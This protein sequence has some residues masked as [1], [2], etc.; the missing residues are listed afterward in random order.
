MQNLK[1]NILHFLQE[2]KGS[3]KFA[4]IQTADFLFPGLEID[5]VGEVAFP[6]NRLQAEALIEVAHKAPF[7]K[8]RETILDATV[9]SAWEIDADRLHFN[10][11]AWQKFLHKLIRN[12]KSDLGLEDY[13]VAAHLYKL[14]IYE[15]GDFFLPHKD[16]E[17]EKGM[18]G[19]LII[20]LPSKHSGG[21]L[22]ISFD[23]VTETAHFAE[24]TSNHAIG[25][26]AFYVD[27]DH[28]VKPVTSGHRVCLVYNLIQKKADE[29]IALQ[30]LQNHAQKLAREFAEAE[31]HHRSPFVTLLG[32]QYTPENFSQDMLKLNDRGKAEVLLQ[33]VR[34]NGYYAKL[35][36]VTS[37]QN[38]LPKSGSYDYYNTPE[39]DD[40]EME[41]V[42]DENLSIAHWANDG[43]P[44]FDEI[45]LE[46]D[47]IITS[48]ALGEGEP[49]MKENSG[50]MGNY[51][52]ELMYWYHYGAVMI[53]SPEQ[54]AEMLL[55]QNTETQ[56]QWIAHF[57]QA[58]QVSDEEIAAVEQILSAGLTQR[59]KPSG[60]ANFNVVANWLIQQKTMPF[61][62][63]LNAERLQYFFTLI[64]ADHWTKLLSN[65]Q[66]R[67]SKKILKSATENMTKPV[68][69]KIIDIIK[70]AVDSAHLK[71]TALEQMH[72]LPGYLQAITAEGKH[73]IAVPALKELFWIAHHFP[74]EFP[75]KA[76]A[77]SLTTGMRKTYA[78][79]VLVPQVLATK[80]RSGFVELLIATC[81]AFMKELVHNKPEPPTDWR[82]PLPETKSYG[83]QWEILKP[84]M[85]S[86]DDMRF[87]FCRK[88][89][90]RT[91]MSEAIRK[92]TVDL[93]TETIRKGSP[94]TL[95][96]TKTQ[97]S[98][99]VAR[100]EWEGD[101]V[102]LGRLGEVN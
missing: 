61:L 92:V 23:G 40:M 41:E 52:P 60:T 7:G 29:P 12:V 63:K 58:E 19:T 50:Y 102:L 5:G 33:V 74:D 93:K 15:N 36:L 69:E 10:N 98:Y 47:D 35:C 28:E 83:E 88:L 51:G 101:V 70:V 20:G 90:E 64:D 39:A 14:L 2:L 30:S 76:A 21:E 25:C 13:T 22:V 49:V 82:R 89:N 32:H 55:S 31:E 84:F 11:P 45:H 9:R 65:L 3:G 26:A 53:W 91:A 94:H 56:Q 81:S 73:G 86:P 100:R 71:P 34:L 67:E 37:Y 57:T 8:G 75:A 18:F 97:D 87:D 27:C 72:Q 42:Y 54:H 46:E 79:D 48:F 68:L 96:I 44:G 16:S 80:L 43:L 99:V 77:E 1:K 4:S 59:I 24:A 85:E 17:K 62:L 6:V 38:G 95:R 66:V 78:R